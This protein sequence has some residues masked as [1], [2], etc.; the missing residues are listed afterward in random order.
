VLSTSRHLSQ[1]A[2]DLVNLVWDEQRQ[3]LSGISQ[4]VAG[5]AYEI[6]L[7]LP[8]EYRMISDEFSALAPEIRQIAPNVW[9]LV[10]A[11]A[12][13]GEFP[14]SVAFNPV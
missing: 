4:G 10:F 3:T 12:A 1:G 7:H 2:V 8:D 6:V 13:T 5:D 11:P 9:G 14:W